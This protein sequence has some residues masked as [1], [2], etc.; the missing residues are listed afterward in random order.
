M[1]RLG[2]E[3]LRNKL[4]QPLKKEGEVNQRLQE[5]KRK[6]GAVLI[7]MV[8]SVSRFSR[9]ITLFYAISFQVRLFHF[10]NDYE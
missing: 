3:N 9:L 8:S 10:Y 5:I 1:M 4:S 6:E 2:S 7:D